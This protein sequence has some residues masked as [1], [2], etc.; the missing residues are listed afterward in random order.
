MIQ[1]N[2]LHLHKDHQV[3]PALEMNQT[4]QQLPPIVYIHRGNWHIAW[5]LPDRGVI[6]RT[7]RA[8]P[9]EHCVVRD[10]T[11]ATPQSS[12]RAAINGGFFYAPNSRYP[13]YY[14]LYT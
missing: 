13:H 6:F 8:N 14:T 11:N 5:C 4:A 12:V 3:K 7:V 1:D 10:F 2:H 9:A